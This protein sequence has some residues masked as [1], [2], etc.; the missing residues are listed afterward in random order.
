M[1]T[2]YILD[3]LSNLKAKVA[4]NETNIATNKTNIAANKKS[5]DDHKADDA[6]HW[7]TADRT[8]FDRVVHFKGYFTTEAA[9]IAAHST[10]QLGDYA[11]VG[12]TDTVWLW[13]DTKNKWLNSTEQ[14]IVISVNNRTG[15][16]V[17]TKTDVG[18]SNVD[19]TA[20][21]KKPV[22]EA[23][24]AALDDK[25]DRKVI[26]ESEVDSFILRAGTYDFTGVSRTI[27]GVT[28]EK[29][30][31]IVGEEYVEGADGADPTITSATQI[32]MNYETTVDVEQHIY[33]RFKKNT[34]SGDVWSDYKELT[35]NTAMSDLQT[36]VTNNKNALKDKADR[37]QITAAEA[38]GFDL[39]AGIYDLNNKTKKILNVESN[40]WTV[41]VGGSV[42]ADRN[43]NYSTIQIWSSY[44]TKDGSIPRMFFRRQYRE[45]NTRYW[46][47][48]VEI[49]T[50]NSISNVDITHIKNYKGYYAT[51][52]DL[53]TAHA[54]GTAGDYAI[55]G[56]SF[57]VWD[58][59]KNTWTKIS[60]GGG[61]G[62]AVTSVNDKTGAV[63][64]T[65]ADIGLTNVD[66]TAD[67]DKVVKSATSATNDSD[68]NKIVDT[69]VK[70]AGDTMTGDLTMEKGRINLTKNSSLSYDKDKGII[71]FYIDS[72]AVATLDS[73][74]I[75]TAARFV[76]TV[77]GFDSS[78]SGIG[79][80]NL[81]LG[82]VVIYPLATAPE[83]WLLC[84]G[85]AVSRTEYADLFALLGTTYGAGDGST[86]F[87]LPDFK[88]RTP[89]GYDADSDI[90][91]I[92]GLKD[93]EKEHLL[94]VSE[95]PST[96]L[97]NLDGVYIEN[98][99]GTYRTLDGTAEAHNNMQPYIVQ[100]FIIKAVDSNSGSSGIGGGGTSDITVL[101]EKSESTHSVYSA[102]Y[103]NDAIET[104]KQAA[105]K[106]V[107][108]AIKAL[109]AEM[110]EKI[111]TKEVVAD[112]IIMEGIPQM[113]SDEYKTNNP[114][115]FIDREHTGTS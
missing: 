87:N 114:D 95:I 23:Q 85:R 79:N 66:N 37:R 71:Y 34:D 51:V 112:A 59:T 70:K 102:K 88:Q 90:A 14:G 99:G 63:V 101:N 15:E 113:Y 93:G 3:L 36:Q 24:Q 68:G 76:E 69:Y 67:A 54:T 61:G 27:L 75:F 89:I 41:I 98:T 82:T 31:V 20:D 6:R 39:E 26:T 50:T 74:G 53:T 38:D 10:G 103:V 48:F 4:T 65:K 57:Y 100:N 5:I 73:N 56:D 94:K 115:K 1:A 72:V 17:L 58:G 13:D 8:N 35:T 91:S 104:A 25:A 105:L 49:L 18:L 21:N 2:P 9:L 64:L 110:A 46:S 7:T 77:G 55:V 60:G 97:S 11:I 42:F 96:S 78:T 19:N 111:T 62:G 43:E 108:D 44:E 47:D 33:I 28:S 86:T 84:D 52:A 16:V 30:T 22:S 106:Y 107:D 92:L 81:P 40:Y 80:G 109:K 83:G 29:W 12:E 45:V 32:W